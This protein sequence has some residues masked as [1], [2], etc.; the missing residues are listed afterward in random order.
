MKKIIALF[1]LITTLFSLSA[2]S[3]FQGNDKNPPERIKIRIGYMAGPTG[4]GMA[5]LISDNGGLE[6]GNEKYSFTK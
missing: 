6:N 3:C 1:L 5:K 4:M 2:C